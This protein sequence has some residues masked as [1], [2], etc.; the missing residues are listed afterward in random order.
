MAEVEGSSGGGRVKVSSRELVMWAL[1]VGLVGLMVFI[2]DGVGHDHDDFVGAQ[3]PAFAAR[4]TDGSI[5]DLEALR[6]KVVVLNFYANWC[7]PCREE[8]PEFARFDQRNRELGRDVVVLGVV[9][10]SGAPAEAEAGSRK[11]GVTY[12][13]VHGTQPLVE[14]YHLHSYPLTV[15]IDAKGRVVGRADRAVTFGELERW[16]GAAMGGGGAS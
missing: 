9:L 7:P 13:I 12:P 5:T 1:V 4:A 16:V 6:G 14:R 15:V 3:A 11:L 10:E 8:I 2:S